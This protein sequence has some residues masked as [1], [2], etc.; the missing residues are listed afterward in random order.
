MLGRGYWEPLRGSASTKPFRGGHPQ[1]R[2]TQGPGLGGGSGPATTRPLLVQSGEVM[3]EVG[4]SRPILGP[5][6]Q[7]FRKR[8]DPKSEYTK[9]VLIL[10][11][12]LSS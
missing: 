2:Q 3:G 5:Q 9:D 6:L 11:M 12:E 10:R 4:I 1:G 7:V 8:S